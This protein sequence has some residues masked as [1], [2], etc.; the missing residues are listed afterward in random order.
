MFRPEHMIIV[1]ALA[2]HSDAQGMASP[3][4]S[5]I[6]AIPQGAV[7]I[8]PGPAAPPPQSDNVRRTLTPSID[9][10][11]GVACPILWNP[12]PSQNAPKP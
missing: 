3:A 5:E 2:L 9:C 10:T 1:L 4:V 8:L 12:K 6:A 7:G 11:F